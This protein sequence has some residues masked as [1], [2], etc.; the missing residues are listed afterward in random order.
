MSNEELNIKEIWKVVR[1]QA[2]Q[3][4]DLTDTLEDKNNRILELEKT[5]TTQGD[6]IIHLKKRL[7][8]LTSGESTKVKLQSELKQDD[9]LHVPVNKTEREKS[10]LKHHPLNHAMV[11]RDANRVRRQ[12]LVLYRDK[13]RTD[14]IDYYTTHIIIIQLL[15]A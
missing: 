9:I 13:I 6:E 7:E 2:R 12:G 4:N 11:N 10:I 14:N 1:D 5:V 3:L 15:S 8:H